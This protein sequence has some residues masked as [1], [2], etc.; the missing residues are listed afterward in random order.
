MF[1]NLTEIGTDPIMALMSEFQQDSRADKIELGIGVY[2]DDHG[3]T[4]IMAAVQ[5]AQDRVKSQQ[6][7]KSYLGLAGNEKFNQ[8]TL[9]LLFSGSELINRA[10][11]FQTPGG[12]GALRLFAELAKMLSP[13][14]RVWLPQQTFAN[15][16]LTMAAVNLDVVYYPYLDLLTQL[17]DEPAMLAALSQANANDIVL[18]HGCC[19]NPTG[20]DISLAQWQALAELSNSNGFLPLIDLAYQGF[21]E[22][23]NQ[24]I[25][26]LRQLCSSVPSALVSVSYSKNMGLYRER[27]GCAIVVGDTLTKANLVK[28]HL[29]RI[30]C[31]SYAMPPDHGAA[32]VGE[33]LNDSRLFADW[34]SELA[35]MNAR[36]RGLRQHLVA[37]LNR[38]GDHTFDFITQHRGL[39]SLTGLTESQIARLKAEFAVYVVN[40]GRINIAGLAQSQ[41]E[42]LALALT[43]VASSN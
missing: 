11:G 7:S 10:C 24:D 22:D 5:S 36:L 3:Q 26:G 13:Q 39:F 23:L 31:G 12:S 42:Q 16:P 20:A 29:L 35:A 15:H 32:L 8:A 6:Q 1:N 9:E 4:P 28:K 38:R 40:G 17:V 41:C 43:T 37:T 19:H 18:L 34:A 2:K 14:A 27:T 33:I 21:G 25:L 30:A